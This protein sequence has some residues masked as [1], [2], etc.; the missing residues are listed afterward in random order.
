MKPLQSALL[1]LITAASLG[2]A[3]GATVSFSSGM[4]FTT[5]QAADGSPLNQGYLHAGYYAGDPVGLNSADLRDNFVP[6]MTFG[7]DS[8]PAGFFGNADFPVEPV[9]GAAGSQIYLVA[10]DSADPAVA[11]QIAV[12][13]NDTDPD[14]EYPATDLGFT[15]SV[16]MDDIIN[17]VPG[18]VILA[19]AES[20]QYGGPSI[21]LNTVV[22][23]PSSSLLAALACLGLLV[24]R[25]R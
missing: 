19:G 6:W 25:Q 3:S 13:T 17:A 12:F 18:A 11:S 15:P 10:T 9:A 20:T 2:I 1:G 5:F 14:W 22:P 21:Q 24:R 8:G 4:S 7:S 16:S 23:E